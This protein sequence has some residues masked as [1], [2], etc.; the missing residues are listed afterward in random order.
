[1]I[2]SIGL[3]E[4][5]FSLEKLEK[6][7]IDETTKRQFPHLNIS[8]VCDS[9]SS[10]L[11]D[12][13][14]LESDITLFSTYNDEEYSSIIFYVFGESYFYAHHDAPVYGTAV[15]S[16]KI[17]LD[18]RS[19]VAVAT[20]ENDVSLYDVCVKN[21]VYPQ[22]T[23]CGHRD[24]VVSV[25]VLNNQLYT[26]S[27]DRSVIKWDIAR[28][29]PSERYEFGYEVHKL[30][31]GNGFV[32]AAHRDITVMQENEKLEIKHTAEIEHLLVRDNM[33]YVSNIHGY[34]LCFDLRFPDRTLL[35][36]K[37]HADA[38]SSFDIGSGYIVTG[39]FDQSIKVVDADDFSE[40]KHIKTNDF[41]SSLKIC[42]YTKEICFYGERT[43]KLRH[44]YI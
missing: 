32:V 2:S 16:Q 12:E 13:R 20:Y 39:S 21:M 11:E 9:D 18:S 7:E 29:E 43:T 6:Y 24:S 27:Q 41:V 34:L 10:E 19:Y 44:F 22:A 42:D 28:K 17:T 35:Q 8:E 25:D 4:K 37:V 15:D 14:I 31:V 23:L 40:K 30:G 38:I 33:L 5:K 3:L 36:K 26:G 1:M